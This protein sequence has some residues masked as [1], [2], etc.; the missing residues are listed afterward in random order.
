MN[1][2]LIDCDLKWFC[3]SQIWIIQHNQPI[4]GSR[5]IQSHKKFADKISAIDQYT[6]TASNLY[7]LSVFWPET[8]YESFIEVY[9]LNV[10]CK[11]YTHCL[12]LDPLHSVRNKFHWKPSKRFDKNRQTMKGDT[13]LTTK[14][15]HKGKQRRKNTK[16]QW[17][18]YGERER[19]REKRTS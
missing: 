1:Y 14:K 10:A 16:H 5:G 4:L 11:M 12:N 18:T 7:T 13:K 6:N 19:E 9:I 2:I 17:Y 15:W 8:F 3:V